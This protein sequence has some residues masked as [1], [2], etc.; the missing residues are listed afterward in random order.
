MRSHGANE[1]ILQETHE[2]IKLAHVVHIGRTHWLINHFDAPAL[3]KSLQNRIL[4][5]KGEGCM[6]RLFASVT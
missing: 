1:I 2:T 4:R 5:P 3:V 6:R